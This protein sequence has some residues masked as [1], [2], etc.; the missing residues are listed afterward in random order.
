MGRRLL[1]LLLLVAIVA[2]TGAHTLAASEITLDLWDQFT[3]GTGFQK[4]VDTFQA[5]NPGLKIKRNPIGGSDIRQVLR[6]ALAA[7]SGPELFYYEV[8]G[9]LMELARAGLVYDLS[10]D[11]KKYGWDKKIAASGLGSVRIDGKIWSIPNELELQ[12]VV[13]YHKSDFKKLGLSV[14]RTYKDFEKICEKF[15][16]SGVLPLC[17]G[18]SKGAF[19]MRFFNLFSAYLA[20]PDKLDEVLYGNG[21]WTAA[22]FL[23]AARMVKSLADKGYMTNASNALSTGDARAVFIS[24]KAGMCVSGTWDN[25]RF[26]TED[27]RADDLDFFNI[28]PPSVLTSPRTI[29]GTGSGFCINSTAK[30]DKLA[31]AVKFLNFL[32]SETASKI[33]VED[34]LIIPGARPDLSKMSAHPLVS[35][36]LKLLFEEKA[37]RNLS[38]YLP[39]DVH[40]SARS[41]SQGLWSGQV[42]PEKFIAELDRLWSAAKK[43]NRIFV[44][45]K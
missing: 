1:T 32:T 38:T 41:V 9:Q 34:V 6:T 10:A 28:P 22:P 26:M 13:Y 21:S 16:A 30:G 12:L 27:A 3:E 24:G 25:R 39:S 44:A 19:G 2:L 11:Y 31:A 42:T 20:G 35:K 36:T 4:L 29:V 17:C 33:W 23:E 15:K 37:T 40:T 43:E 5:E 7:G 8:G 14:P 18:S 45:G